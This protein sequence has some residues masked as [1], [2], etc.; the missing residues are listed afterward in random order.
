MRRFAYLRRVDA[1]LRPLLDLA[2]DRERADAAITLL[3]QHDDELED[4]IAGADFGGPS[5]LA[6]GFQGPV[7]VSTGLPLQADAGGVVR[8]RAT[9]AVAGGTDTTVALYKNGVS[10]A[11]VTIGAGQTTGSSAVSVALALGDVLTPVIT[12]AG[13][14]AVDLTVQADY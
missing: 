6:W 9:L 1:I 5:G 10:A 4:W 8:L 13:A 3:Q 14:N 2:P 12:T 11:I 7:I